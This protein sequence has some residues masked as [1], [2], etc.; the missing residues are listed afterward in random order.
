MIGSKL[1]LAS[2]IVHNTY[3]QDEFRFVTPNCLASNHISATRALLPANNSTFNSMD[4][5][6]SNT[7]LQA[8]DDSRPNVTLKFHP[9]SLSVIDFTPA[10]RRFFV[11]VARPDVFGEEGSSFLTIRTMP[12]VIVVSEGG[13][14]TFLIFDRGARTFPYFEVPLF[15]WP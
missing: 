14:G 9:F 8:K 6:P 4:T 2:I 10:K 13:K 7:S 1:D 12:A 15:Q 3:L 5:G 11:I